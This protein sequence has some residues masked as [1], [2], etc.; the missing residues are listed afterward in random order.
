MKELNVI[1]NKNI[2]NIF[3]DIFD[4]IVFRSVQ[5]EYVMNTTNDN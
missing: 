5:P 4:T 2:K 3:L 1:H